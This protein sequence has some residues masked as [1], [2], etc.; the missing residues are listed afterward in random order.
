MQ[1]AGAVLPLRYPPPPIARSDVS[2]GVRVLQEGGVARVQCSGY[3]AL[4]DLAQGQLVGLMA[5]DGTSL[6]SSPR[7]CA[8]GGAQPKRD[9]WMRTCDILLR[10]R[11]GHVHQGWSA[12]VPP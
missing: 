7:V 1:G 4:L 2:S 10:M 11:F 8:Q 9:A 3:S 12:A 6:V 5:A